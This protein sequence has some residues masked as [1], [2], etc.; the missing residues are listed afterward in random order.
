MGHEND[1][2]LE[3]KYQLHR[4]ELVCE[5]NKTYTTDGGVIFF[6]I[7]GISSCLEQEILRKI[8]NTE[9]GALFGEMCVVSKS[10]D[11]NVREADFQ[12]QP[13]RPE[14]SDISFE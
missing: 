9:T 14:I 5:G 7:M 4:G 13:W 3:A 6:V 11:P 8:E 12:A 2:M 1:W 10:K